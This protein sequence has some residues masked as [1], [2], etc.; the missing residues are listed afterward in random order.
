MIKVSVIKCV[1]ASG[2]FALL[3]EREN[4][5]TGEVYKGIVI[6]AQKPRTGY[7]IGR[8]ED[9]LASI[10]KQYNTQHDEIVKKLGE[11]V[12]VKK[13]DPKDDTKMIDVNTGGHRVKEENMIEYREAV[14]KLQETEEQIPI[15]ALDFEMFEGIDFPQEF[16]TAMIPFMSE[17][18]SDKKEEALKKTE[19]LV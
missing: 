5:R 9:Y 18:K 4:K 13:V 7:W 11:P 6:P 8:L 14:K 10:F 15:N 3:K 19:V 16:W 12:M 1:T 2:V 17:P